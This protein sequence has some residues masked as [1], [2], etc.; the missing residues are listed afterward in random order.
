MASRG[1][2][3]SWGTSLL[4]QPSPRAVAGKGTLPA[5]RPGLRSR[6]GAGRAFATR[7]WGLQPGAPGA[8][9]RDSDAA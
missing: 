7:G 4:A 8:E 6:V 9:A 3:V 5:R 2:G 1:S